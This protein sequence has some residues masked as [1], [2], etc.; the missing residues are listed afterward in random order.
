[1]RELVLVKSSNDNHLRFNSINS[2]E[3]DEL[4]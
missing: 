2:Q 1:M 4:E 3:E